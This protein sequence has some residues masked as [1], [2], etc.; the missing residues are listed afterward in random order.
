MRVVH[1]YD[2]DKACQFEFAVIVARHQG[3]WVFCK[4]R[5]RGTWECPGGHW[6]QGETIEETA[7]R[8]LY[9]ETGALDF[10]LTPVCV[11]SVVNEVPRITLQES[12]GMLYYADISSF[13]PLPEMEIERIRLSEDYPES[14]T[15]PDIQPILMEKVKE[16]VTESL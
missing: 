12:F 6:E 13:G 14:W 15:Y 2:Q 4:H 3:K 7:R 1:L 5:E 11:Y 9:E 16:A 10:S 8:E